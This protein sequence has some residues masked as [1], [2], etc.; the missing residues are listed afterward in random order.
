MYRI[1]ISHSSNE[2]DEAKALRNWLVLQDPPLANEI[3]L[4]ADMMRAGLQWKNQLK[5][6]MSHCEAVICLVSAKWIASHECLA[7][8]R[9]AEYLDKRIFSARLES[10]ADLDVDDITHEWQRVDLFGPGEKTDVLVD[11][12]GPSVTFLTEGLLRLKDEIIKKGIGA[13]SFVWPPP[14]EEDRAPYRGWAPLE[15]VDAAVYF[16]RDAELVRAW[17]KLRGMRKSGEE[18]LFVI[19]GPSGSGKSSFLRAGLLPRLRRAD[20]NFV[21][22]DRIVRP[23]N[24]VLTGKNGLAEAIHAT[25]IR[26]GLKESLL[27]DIQEAC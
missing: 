18:S 2:V 7:E 23:E 25:R 16:G 20:R 17:D 24:N 3:F 21:V 19:L 22:L 10:A 12:G 8:Y 1:F 9:A 14:G 5:Q 4:D 15:E 6:A 11:D 26:L 13:E 27:A